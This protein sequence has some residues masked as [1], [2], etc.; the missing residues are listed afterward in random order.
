MFRLNG[1]VA[2]VSGGARGIGAAVAQALADE[3]AK[4]V[5]GD[6]LDEEGQARAE[7]IGPSAT[8][9]HLDVTNPDDWKAAVATAVERYGKLDVLVNNAGIAQ[10]AP[11]DQYPRADWD[12]ILA[13]NLTGVF[14]GIQAAVPA[15]KNAGGGSIVDMSSILGL[16]AV[17][18]SAGYV[19]TKFGVRG[20]T[21]AAAVDLG[22][23]GIRV[24]SVHPGFIST[25]MTVATPPDTSVVA[26]G[27]PGVPEDVAKLVV[28]LASDESSFSTGAEFVVDGGET[29]GEANGGSLSATLGPNGLL[30]Q[31][32]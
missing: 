19:A 26:L 24:N 1:K 16:T 23:Y 10:A 18:A 3:D 11:I 7:L 12:K 8:Y 14:N 21:K 17:P 15:M 25:P 32:G 28:F 22:G 31:T 5:I 9:V 2:L 30:A 13:V 6:L 4:V 27:R 20:L 29:A